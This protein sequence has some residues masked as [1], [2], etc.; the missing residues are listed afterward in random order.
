MANY[1]NVIKLMRIPSHT[2]VIG[3]KEV[4]LLANLQAIYIVP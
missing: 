1:N 2:G 3:N 4:D